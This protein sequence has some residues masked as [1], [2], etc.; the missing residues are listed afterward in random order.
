MKKLLIIILTLQLITIILCML[1]I[2]NKNDKYDRTI[3]NDTIINRVR[4]DSVHFLISK[5]ESIINIINNKEQY[6]IKQAVSANDSD[7]IKL[8][9]KLVTE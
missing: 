6:E 8:F 1:L 9:K 2:V 5:Q 3:I 4:I 7:V